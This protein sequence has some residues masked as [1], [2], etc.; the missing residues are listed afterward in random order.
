MPSV[1]GSTAAPRKRTDAVE[2]LGVD[3]ALVDK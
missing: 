1:F 2:T 3:L